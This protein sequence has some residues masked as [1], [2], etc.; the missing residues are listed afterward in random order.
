MNVVEPTGVVLFQLLAEVGVQQ[1][2][3]WSSGLVTFGD[4]LICDF[5][6]IKRAYLSF[7]VEVIW[8]LGHE[9]IMRN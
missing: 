2:S 3:V 6:P 8:V 7:E 4:G 1:V 5:S 9:Q